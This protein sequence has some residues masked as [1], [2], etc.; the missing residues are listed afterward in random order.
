MKPE[1]LFQCKKS[2]AEFM[3][4][5]VDSDGIAHS[6]RIP[7]LKVTD[8]KYDTSWDALMP[9]IEKIGSGFDVRITWVPE[10]INVT[11]IC[12]PSVYDSEITSMGGLTVIENTFV[13]VVRFIEWYNTKS[14]YRKSTPKKM[15]E[16]T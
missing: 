8:L 10:A 1:L 6:D 15:S 5:E 4:Y 2:I 13:A 11:Y 3:G 9:V 12:R 16:M 7:I 14:Q